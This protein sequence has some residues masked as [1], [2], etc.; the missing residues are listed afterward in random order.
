ME[1]KEFICISCP[2][3]CSLQVWEENGEIFVEGNTCPRGK[4]YG[5]Q[6]YTAPVRT[7]T[8]SVP[9]SGGDME[10]VSVKTAQSVPKKSIP[11]VL[12]NIHALRVA[13]PVKVGQVLL[14]DV[15]GTGVD[16]VAT[17]NVEAR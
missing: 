17:R 3:G 5:I 14:A 15:A 10:M 8:S 9:V 7:V 2:V 6:E 16:V 13:A 11:E 4:K 1:K 12:E